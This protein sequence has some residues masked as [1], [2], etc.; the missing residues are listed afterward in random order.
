MAS[1]SNHPDFMVQVDGAFDD[2]GT[3]VIDVKLTIRE[4]LS[5]EATARLRPVW[6]AV[7]RQG[8]AL[9]RSR[10]ADRGARAFRLHLEQDPPGRFR[11]TRVR[12]AAD[13]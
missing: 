7:V 3:W 8:V 1:T 4:G 5:R 9:E 12:A 13:L 10:G 11:R 2:G 6:A